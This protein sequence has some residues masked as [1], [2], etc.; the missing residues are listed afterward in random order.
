LRAQV[1]NLLHSYSLI[2]DT[3]FQNYH[4]YQYKKVLD[5]MRMQSDI[6]ALFKKDGELKDKRKQLA[7]RLGVAEE[8]VAEIAYDHLLQTLQTMKN[9]DGSQRHVP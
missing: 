7:E 6:N 9:A 4:R 3:P 5:G 8:R 2:I 1:V